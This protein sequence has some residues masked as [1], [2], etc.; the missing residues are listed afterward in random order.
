MGAVM[1][2]SWEKCHMPGRLFCAWQVQAGLTVVGREANGVRRYAAVLSLGA[3]SV[4]MS[5]KLKMMT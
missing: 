1:V 2:R 3:P 4:G 5:A